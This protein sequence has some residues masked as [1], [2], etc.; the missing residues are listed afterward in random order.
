MTMDLT[1]PLLFACA[2]VGTVLVGAAEEVK[3]L[4]AFCAGFCLEAPLY[5]WVEWRRG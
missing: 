1:M 3:L 4:A 5:A 2:W